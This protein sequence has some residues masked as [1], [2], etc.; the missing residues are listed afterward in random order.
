MGEVYRGRDAKLDRDVA[1]KVLAQHLTADPDALARFER[2]DDLALAHGLLD[3]ETSDAAGGPTWLTTHGLPLVPR[4]L[5][6]AFS[7]GW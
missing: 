2:A 7:V 3:D 1:I 4:L 6:E 5:G